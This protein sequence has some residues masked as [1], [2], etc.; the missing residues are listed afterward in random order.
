MTIR[1]LTLTLRAGG[2]TMSGLVSR[3]QVF[4]IGTGAADPGAKVNPDLA[5]TQ[6]IVN[7]TEVL[8]VIALL[9]IDIRDERE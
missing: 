5:K 2:I 3:E 6:A 8:K 1:L 7:V 4:A 9:L